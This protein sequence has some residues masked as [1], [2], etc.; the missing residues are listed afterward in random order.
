MLIL[1][2]LLLSSIGFVFYKS[3]LFFETPRQGD[4]NWESSKHVDSA[5]VLIKLL[6]DNDN[7]PQLSTELVNLTL[8]EDVPVGRS[9]ATF[10]AS[11]RDQVGSE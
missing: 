4:S 5:W 11:D 8:P 6:D 7:A 10:T 2:C 9:L 1:S 3:Y